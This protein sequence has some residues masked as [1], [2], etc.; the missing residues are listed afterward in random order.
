MAYPYYSRIT[1]KRLITYIGVMPDSSNEHHRKFSRMAYP[2]YTRHCVHLLM[3]R[4][5]PTISRRNS[6]GLLAYTCVIQPK[7]IDLPEQRQ[8]AFANHA[9]MLVIQPKL[10]SDF[11]RATASCFARPCLYHKQRANAP[12]TA[13]R[14]RAYPGLPPKPSTP[15]TKPHTKR[16]RTH[17]QEN[18]QRES[19]PQQ[20]S[21]VKKRRQ[22][23]KEAKT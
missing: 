10:I 3:I 2:N 5:M 8:T 9:N 20:R 17:P 19:H 6:R 16:R 7:L 22:A 14:P 23:A 18:A 13:T 1:A 21:R 11:A 12:N 4:P 15:N